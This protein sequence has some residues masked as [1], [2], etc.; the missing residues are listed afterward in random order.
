MS[1]PLWFI[2]TGILC[3]VMLVRIGRGEID[4]DP[5]LH[6]ADFLVQKNDAPLAYSDSRLLPGLPLILASVISV[7]PINRFTLV[8]FMLGWW[9]ASSYLIAKISANDKM[10]WVLLFPPIM[11][12]QMTQIS[13]ESVLVMI[14]L[15]TLRWWQKKRYQ[16]ASLCL[17]LGMW[18]RL[19]SAAFFVAL[20]CKLFQEKKYKL[21]ITTTA[22]FLV[23]LVALFW[24][25]TRLFGAGSELQQLFTYV[26]VGRAQPALIQLGRDVWRAWEWGWLRILFSGLVYLGFWLGLFRQAWINAHRAKKNK[27]TRLW[28][29]VG[30]SMSVFVF[31]VGPTPFLEEFSRFLVP[32]FMVWQMQ[33]ANQ[34]QIKSWQVVGLTLLSAGVVLA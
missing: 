30:L 24:F 5:Y 13:T 16:L 2:V 11:L 17:G 32:V 27:N 6:Y 12:D 25:N 33:L 9:W 14:L 22:W 3:S 34:V 26:E 19:I 10:W 4:Q 29:A 20:L 8:I 7:V 31:S 23:P 18:F 1:W 28:W 15:T 21:A